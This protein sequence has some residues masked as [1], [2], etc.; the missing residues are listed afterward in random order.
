MFAALRQ[1]DMKHQNWRD[2][3]QDDIYGMRWRW[4]YGAYNADIDTIWCFCPGDYTE[5][6]YLDGYSEVSFRC[7]TCGRKFGPFNG[8]RH[9]VIGMAERQIRRKLRTNEWKAVVERSGP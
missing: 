7:E 8:D 5:L 9:H 3:N 6:V 1:K 2:Y 4:R